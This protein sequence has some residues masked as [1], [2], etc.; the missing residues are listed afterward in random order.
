MENGMGL[1]MNDEFA[2]PDFNSSRL[3][4]RFIR[5]METLAGQP[6]KSIW[7]CSKN[8]AE[9]KAA[10]RM[11]SNDKLDREEILRTH[12][13][14]TIRRMLRSEQTIPAVQDTTGLNYNRQTKMEG[15]GYIGEK[16]LGVN[17][18]SR[19]AVTV[20]GLVLG[21]LARSSYNRRQPKDTTRRHDGK[22]VRALQEKESFRRIQTLGESTI[23]VPETV[24]V[25]TVCDRE[26]DM[27]EL[28]DEADSEGQAF[29]YRTERR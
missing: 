2:T 24:H 21:V 20:G 7:F 9:A 16:T 27:Y 11:L 6:D 17:I 15:I 8:R 10:Y 4:K 19:L 23:N 14:A 22:K 13:E 1:S 29:Q 5:T 3:E 25:L 12:R 18:H 26:G 28:F